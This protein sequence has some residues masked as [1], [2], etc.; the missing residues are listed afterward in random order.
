MGFVFVE[1]LA[2]LVKRILLYVYFSG[3]FAGSAGVY[4]VAVVFF[5]G[6]CWITRSLS[7]GCCIFQAGLLDHQEFIQWLLYFSGGFAGSPGV[8]TVAVVFFKRVCWITR[9]LSSGCCIFQEGL[10]DH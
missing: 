9:S 2:H 7:S 3:G 6:V 8:Y 4:P 10:V 1:T 5:R